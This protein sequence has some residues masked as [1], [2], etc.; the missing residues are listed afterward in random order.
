[1]L[2]SNLYPVA[3]I[4]LVRLAS[5]KLSWLGRDLKDNLAKADR[6]EADFVKSVDEF[7][8]KNGIDAPQEVFPD[9]RNGYD[10]DE[11]IMILPS[12]SLSGE[13]WLA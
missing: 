6:F 12:C 3:Q 10:V 4:T 2:K 1:M 13:F 5:L 7:S 9:L 8:A 11:L